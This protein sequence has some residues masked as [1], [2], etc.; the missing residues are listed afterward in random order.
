VQI[1]FP[2]LAHGVGLYEVSLIMDM[3]AVIGSV[4]L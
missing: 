2:S 3:K 4:I 1:N